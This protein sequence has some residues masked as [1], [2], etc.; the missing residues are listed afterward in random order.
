MKEM[1][2]KIKEKLRE[3]FIKIHQLRKAKEVTAT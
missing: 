2:A 3:K 1:K